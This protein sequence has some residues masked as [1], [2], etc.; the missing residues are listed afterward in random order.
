MCFLGGR[1]GKGLHVVPLKN[2]RRVNVGVATFRCRS[3]VIIMSYN[4]TF[5]RS[6]VLK[7]SLMVPSMA[8]LGSGVSGMG[9]FIVARNRRSRVNTLPCMLGRVGVPVC[10]AGLAVKVV[11]GGL[12]RRGLL[13]KAGEG[14]MH[15]NRSVGLKGFQVRFVGAG[16]DVRSTSTLTVCSP[17]NIIIRAKSFGISCAPMFKSTVSLRHFTRV[18]GGNI[19]TLVSSDAGTRQGKFAR[20][21]HAMNVAFSRVFT[22]RRGAELVVTAFTSGISHMRRVVGSTC[23]CNEGIIMRNHDVIGVVSATSRLK[24]LGMPSGALVRVSRVGGC[25]PRGVILVAAKDR[26]RSVTTLSEVTT[27]MRHGIAVR[28][29]SAVVF[30]SGPVPKGR[31]SISHIVGRLSTGKTRIVFRSTRMSKRTYRRRLGLVCSLMGPGCTVPIRN[32]C[33]RLGTG[34]NITGDL[35]VPGR[36]MFVVRSNRMLRLYSSCTG[37]MSGIRAKTVLMSKLNIKSIKGVILQS[38]RRLTRSNVVVIIL[39]LREEAGHLLTKPSVMS[40]KFICIERSRRLVSSTE[41]TISRTLRGYLGKE[42]AS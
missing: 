26:K 35:K 2:L 25:P 21:R 29:G 17:T 4:L 18:N 11:R 30:D 3:D 31:G 39:A 6:S 28:P 8:C 1:G 20:S 5:P 41:G 37:I 19:L 36:G 40:E 22:R 16:R 33:H 13:H 38:E 23:G 9:K 15:R 12:G 42:R 34:T 14:I 24:C 32:R 7:V 27:S 10:A